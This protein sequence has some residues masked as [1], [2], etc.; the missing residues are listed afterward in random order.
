MDD[1][2][3]PIENIGFKQKSGNFFILYKDQ[4]AYIY[5]W[6]DLDGNLDDLMHRLEDELEYAWGLDYADINDYNLFNVEIGDHYDLV[7]IEDNFYFEKIKRQS[8]IF[9][10]LIHKSIKTRLIENL[11]EIYEWVRDGVFYL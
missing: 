10:V 1:K 9:I 7:K 6:I 8:E 3:T 5:G 11:P 2:K 4:E